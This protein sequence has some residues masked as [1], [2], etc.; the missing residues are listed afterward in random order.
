M[1]DRA[2]AE[3]SPTSNV[4]EKDAD[5]V[6]GSALKTEESFEPIV[7]FVDSDIVDEKDKE[8]GRFMGYEV[9]GRMSE[10]SASRPIE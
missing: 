9:E 6:L 3:V 1:N 7:E 4:D 5:A 8:L 10:V 2:L